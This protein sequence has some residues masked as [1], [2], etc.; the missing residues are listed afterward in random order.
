MKKSQL[1][2]YIRKY[3]SEIRL[4][5][6]KQ[7]TFK[8]TS[9]EDRID[10]LD[11]ADDNKWLYYTGDLPDANN[12]HIGKEYK[13]V[14]SHSLNAD[15]IYPI[16]EVPYH[17]DVREV[18]LKSGDASK[19]VTPESLIGKPAFNYHNEKGKIVDAAYVSDWRKLT[20]Y[21]DAGWM[22][23][24]DM[25]NADSDTILVAFKTQEGPYSGYDVYTYGDEGVTLASNLGEIRFKSS[26]TE[27]KLYVFRD[28][29]YPGEMEMYVYDPDGYVDDN[30][31]DLYDGSTEIRDGFIAFV[32]DQWYDE[33]VS[34]FKK[35]L[36]DTDIS[37]REQNINGSNT[38][39]IDEDLFK[40]NDVV[41]QHLTKDDIL[42]SGWYNEIPN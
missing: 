1:R 14:H 22:N 15:I 27:K 2:E 36:S 35:Y 28:M 10:F 11:L 33:K 3:I 17:E 24:E 34:R 9:F 12:I 32:T 31:L 5:S 38:I 41:I 20:K 37:Y 29:S 39:L 40:Y 19:V 26:K 4:K 16:D 23:D 25:K 21:D 42:A 18:R 7:S 30:P 13:I 6:D 8:I